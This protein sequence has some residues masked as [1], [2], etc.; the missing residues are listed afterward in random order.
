MLALLRVLATNGSSILLYL[1]HHHTLR[2][3]PDAETAA[4]L[5]LDKSPARN[6]TSAQLASSLSIGAFK[7]GPPVTTT[8]LFVEN[9][10]TIIA[11]M[12]I[13][14][15]AL[16]GDDELIAT[17][18]MQY[19]WNEWNPSIERWNGK[20][21]VAARIIGGNSLYFG[22]LNDT[23]WG[24]ADIAAGYCTR[25]YFGLAPGLNML[26]RGGHIGG[27]P[28]LLALSPTEILVAYS[29]TPVAKQVSRMAA[30]LLRAN[31]SSG[32][33]DLIE[34]YLIHPAWQ[35]DKDSL[36]TY[37]KNW[38]PFLHGGGRLLWAE[39]LDPLTIVTVSPDPN[40]IRRDP[41]I[42]LAFRNAYV[43][44]SSPAHSHWAEWGPM[45]GG[46]PGKLISGGRYLFF[47]HSR[48]LLKHNVATTYF[49]G[50][51]IIS[52]QVTDRVRVRVRV[53]VKSG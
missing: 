4:F 39:S 6:I 35:S 37:H 17:R 22:W 15:Q 21:L 1:L 34:E 36:S 49:F 43:V 9:P 18:T 12:G 25:P 48:R 41:R 7:L 11:Q 24:D 32:T 19:I 10:D 45:H 16:Q 14:L 20:Y 23:G 2:L 8:H 40:E 13:K 42:E 47:F 44:S 51:C 33:L 27:D 5:D 31:H 46:T 3:L 52:A 53:R 26:P 38:A 30:L 50:A 28:R 29:A